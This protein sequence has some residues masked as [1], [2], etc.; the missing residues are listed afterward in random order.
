ME[1]AALL[2]YSEQPMARMQSQLH[3]EHRIKSIP[4]L[5]SHRHLGPPC[6]SRP[7]R[8]STKIVYKLCISRRRHGTHISCGL[9]P[10]CKGL[11]SSSTG[12]E[13]AEQLLLLERYIA[14][15]CSNFHVVFSYL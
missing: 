5:S 10:Y 4:I 9:H 8:T 13:F 14:L 1:L 2:P 7:S 15:A 12:R 3:A 11:H 6:I